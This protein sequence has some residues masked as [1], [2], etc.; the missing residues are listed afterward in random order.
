LAKRRS[1]A[2]LATP[3][4]ARQLAGFSGRQVC[5]S[6]ATGLYLSKGLM[7]AVTASIRNLEDRLWNH[8][9]HSPAK[10]VERTMGDR[11]N[12]IFWL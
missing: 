2:T 7:T 8:A 10:V 11:R 9:E 5:R 6:C 1:S 12:L 4:F 3:N